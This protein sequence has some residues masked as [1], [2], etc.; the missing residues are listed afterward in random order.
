MAEVGARLGVR[1]RS[2]QTGQS[3]GQNGHLGLRCLLQALGAAEDTGWER[4]ENQQQMGVP[5]AFPI[6]ARRCAGA[7]TVPGPPLLFREAKG[8]WG[9]QTAG[10]PHHDC[11]RAGEGRSGVRGGPESSITIAA[12]L[13]QDGWGSGLRTKRPQTSILAGPGWPRTPLRAS[14]VGGRW[15]IPWSPPSSQRC[16]R[17]GGQVSHSLQRPPHPQFSSGAPPSPLNLRI[18]TQIRC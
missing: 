12:E 6:P 1:V 5:A 9:L 3:V 17:A 4:T 2:S 8:G 7:A 14:R 18:F 13:D 10:S 16:L 15:D 11:D